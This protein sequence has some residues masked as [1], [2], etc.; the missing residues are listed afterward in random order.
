[1][2]IMHHCLKT[3]CLDECSSYIEK[4]NEDKRSSGYKMDL[5]S[6]ISLEMP[7]SSQ[8]HCVFPVFRLLTDFVCLLTYDFCL[9]FWNIARCSVI[10]LLPLFKDD[11]QVILM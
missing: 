3:S 9:S 5:T 6:T 8:G 10:L 11:N 4:K 7:V 1:M 2:F